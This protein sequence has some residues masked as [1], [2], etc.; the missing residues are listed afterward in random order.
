MKFKTKKKIELSLEISLFLIALFRAGSVV[1][2]QKKAWHDKPL[3]NLCKQIIISS[4]KWLTDNFFI[5][6]CFYVL[7]CFAAGKILCL[8]SLLHK[9]VLLMNVPHLT[10]CFIALIELRSP[11]V[12][13][14]VKTIGEQIVNIISA[15][16]R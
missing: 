8:W 10:G 2:F 14:I 9:P 3:L 15:L 4:W 7:L 5:I 6:L 13:N 1:Y 16:K 11:N 12:V